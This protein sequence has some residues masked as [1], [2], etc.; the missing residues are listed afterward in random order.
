MQFDDMKYEE[1]KARMEKE[2]VRRAMQVSRY[3]IPEIAE[4]GPEDFAVQGTVILS[5]TGP[6][7]IPWAAGPEELAGICETYIRKKAVSRPVFKKRQ[8]E[9]TGQYNYVR[10]LRKALQ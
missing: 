7:G 6:E 1:L 4:R 5:E 10:S 3:E 2:T 8:E 9:L